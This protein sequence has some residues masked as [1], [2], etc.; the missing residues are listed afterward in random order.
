MKQHLVQLTLSVFT[1]ATVSACAAPDPGAQDE[2]GAYQTL[3]SSS[4]AQSQPSPTDRRLPQLRAMPRADQ[5][6][7]YEL[8][9]TDDNFAERRSPAWQ[10]AVLTPQKPRMSIEQRLQ[11]VHFYAKA[12][13]TAGPRAVATQKLTP[14]LPPQATHSP[15]ASTTPAAS[16][17]EIVVR[18]E[19]VP[20]PA[21]QPGGPVAPVLP[22]PPEAAS[23]VTTNNRPGPTASTGAIG[24]SGALQSSTTANGLLGISGAVAVTSERYGVPGEAA[25]GG[26]VFASGSAIAP[27]TGPASA[28]GLAALR[29]LDRPGDRPV[30]EVSPG[31]TALTGLGSSGSRTGLG[32]GTAAALGNLGQGSTLPGLNGTFFGGVPFTLA[33]PLTSGPAA[34]ASPFAVPPG[35]S[36]PSGAR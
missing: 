15:A 18:V 17:N 4:V 13:A 3:P 22:Q 30:G 23:I 28:D 19:M 16:P 7:A 2:R 12:A 10:A 6:R 20:A 25:S 24:L 9:A 21:V 32:A 33:S 11:S 14:S 31:A 1:T 8:V 35:L 29:T 5:L 26:A 27:G 36:V 34:P